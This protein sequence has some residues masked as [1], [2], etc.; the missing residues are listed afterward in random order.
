METQGDEYG[1]SRT[2]S[3]FLGQKTPYLVLQ[4]VQYCTRY[5]AG[6]RLL[7]EGSEMYYI[8]WIGK[9]NKRWLSMEA[10]DYHETITALVFLSHPEAYIDT[11]VHRDEPE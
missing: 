4:A 6:T 7:K 5:E 3:F 1:L 9:L 8:H 10:G 11:Q 2:R